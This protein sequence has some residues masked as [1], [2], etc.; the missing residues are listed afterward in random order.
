MEVCLDEALEKP[1]SRSATIDWLSVVSRGGNMV[2]GGGNLERLTYSGNI[3]R[4][5]N[6]YRY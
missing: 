6:G 1:M 2:D 5:R 4:G 3:P